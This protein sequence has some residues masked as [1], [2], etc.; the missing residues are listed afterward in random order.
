MSS[1]NQYAPNYPQK[2]QT[3]NTKN[4]TLL[5]KTSL[6]AAAM[7]MVVGCSDNPIPTSS[8]TAASVD[9]EI[10][11]AVESAASNG[12]VV[13][14]ADGLGTGC[15]LKSGDL[16]AIEVDATNAPG[17]Y[18]FMSTPTEPLTA[19]GCKDAHTGADLPPMSA[20]GSKAT[21]SG[22]KKLAL[23]PLTTMVKSYQ[24]AGLSEADAR[25]R[26]AEL[27]GVTDADLDKN[28]VE[29]AAN[30]NDALTKA[31]VKLTALAKTLEKAGNTDP[32]KAFAT[33]TKTKTATTATIDDAVNDDTVIESVV[34]DSTKRAAAKSA[35]NAVKDAINENS[36]AQTGDTLLDTI[37]KIVIAVQKSSV[38]DLTKEKIKTNSANQSLNDAGKKVVVIT[39]DTDLFKAVV[40][41]KKEDVK[42][43][44]TVGFENDDTVKAKVEEKKKIVSG[45]T[46]GN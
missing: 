31:A 23:T 13:T 42:N 38:A 3:M 33:A 5:F 11:T 18:M 43:G 28:P 32:L 20:P 26:T 8:P 19:T 41:K 35:A 2:E 45:A 44:N 15:T 7:S 21:E 40:E 17:Q 1:V 46:A 27:L 29:E 25:A 14:V 37:A 12:T 9:A 10:D 24:D 39:V 4:L 34:T 30:G 6:L 36:D 16:T 22:L